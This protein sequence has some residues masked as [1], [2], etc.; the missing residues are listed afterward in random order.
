MS[1]RGSQELLRIRGVSKEFAPSSGLI[2]QFAHSLGAAPGPAVVRAVTEVDMDI[3]EGEIFGLVGESGCGKSTLGRIIS[4]VYS[5]TRGRIE[6]RGQALANAPPLRIQMIFQDPYASLNPRMRVG[7]IVGQA[8]LVHGL[9]ERAGLRAY[10]AQLLEQVGL[11]PSTTDSYAHQLSGGQR[12]RVSI[13]R[14]LA[15]KPD[16]LVCDEA[17]S[18]L[19]VSIQAQ[20][21]NLFSNLREELGLTIFF[22]S[23]DLG[24][25]RYI[26]DRVA[27]M[28]LG[29]IVEIASTD[30]LFDSPSHPYTQSLLE[31]LPSIHSRGREFSTMRGE[32]PSP[33]KLPRGCAF[34][35][36]CSYA[37]Q[38]CRLEIP[39]LEHIG[40]GHQA[41]C[42]LN[43][44]KTH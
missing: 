40:A 28:Y 6:Y 13:A 42:Y 12:Q 14:A 3:V 15:V 25:I 36:R 21:L 30:A 17:I 8:P 20:I 38:R 43:D 11:D 5:P 18:S 37:M 31:N 7:D 32:I 9:V 35:P 19:D 29:R 39:R 10:V 34:H 33:T 27:V 2:T 41:A 44:Q 22:I 16:L 26:C 4:S 1:S 24:V 23:H